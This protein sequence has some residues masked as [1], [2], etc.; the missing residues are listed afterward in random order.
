MVLTITRENL[1]SFNK[2][3]VL[4]LKTMAVSKKDKVLACRDLMIYCKKKNSK[5]AQQPVL[6][7]ITNCN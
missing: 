1:C 4:V 5:E 7:I 2:Y 6:K 3:I